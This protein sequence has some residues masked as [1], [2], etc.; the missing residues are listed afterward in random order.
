M[1]VCSLLLA[2]GASA[3]A[4]DKKPGDKIE[5]S[6]PREGS[7]ARPPGGTGT[8]EP[9]FNFERRDSGSV[10]TQLPPSQPL[11]QPDDVNRARFLQQLIERRSGLSTDDS[12]RPAVAL[13]DAGPG[14]GNEAFGID[15]LF[16]RQA[17]RRDREGDNRGAM[18][19]ARDDSRGR[20]SAAGR[21]GGREG[22]GAGG[23]EDRSGSGTSGDARLERRDSGF[24]PSME[25]GSLVGREPGSTGR[26]DGFLEGGRSTGRGS[27]SSRDRDDLGAARRA[28][29]ADEWNKLLGRSGTAGERGSLFNGIGADGRTPGGGLTLVPGLSAP[30]GPARNPAETLG[31]RLGGGAPAAAADSTA[32]RSFASPGRSF[33]FDPGGGRGVG[34]SLLDQPAA[35]AAT[36]RAMDLFQQKHDTRLPSRGF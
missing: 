13:D 15:D 17:G 35:P 14:A 25:N 36:V 1:V 21:S 3:F 6:P 11:P 9:R 5:F 7:A 23:S 19:R 32:D 20:D 16:E 4:A 22:D 34:R 10:D 8:R 30:G 18:E 28:Q 12:G 33:D 31:S 26:P 2:L 27:W 24:L 29:R